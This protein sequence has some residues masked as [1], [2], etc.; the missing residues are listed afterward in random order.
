MEK[1]SELYPSVPLPKEVDKYFKPRSAFFDEIRETEAASTNV[2]SITASVETHAIPASSPS[3]VESGDVVGDTFKNSSSLPQ[4]H[5][6]HSNEFGI[7]SPLLGSSLFSLATNPVTSS[8]PATSFADPAMKPK[9]GCTEISRGPIPSRISFSGFG[10]LNLFTSSGGATF[11]DGD[12]LA[13]TE[14][15]LPVE[16]GVSGILLGPATLLLLFRCMVTSTKGP[17]GEFILFVICV[18]WIF[19]ALVKLGDLGTFGNNVL[20]SVFDDAWATLFPL[21]W[22]LALAF[23]RPSALK[24]LIL[25]IATGAIF[26]EFL[27]STLLSHLRSIYIGIIIITGKRFSCP[28]LWSYSFS[29]GLPSKFNGYFRRGEMRDVTIG[30]TNVYPR[31][32][33]FGFEGVRAK[34]GAVFWGLG[35]ACRKCSVITSLVIYGYLCVGLSSAGPRYSSNSSRNT[36][37]GKGDDAKEPTFIHFH[38]REWNLIPNLVYGL[39]GLITITKTNFGIINFAA[40]VLGLCFLHEVGSSGEIICL[41]PFSA[42]VLRRI[43]RSIYRLA[44]FFAWIII[45]DIILLVLQ[46]SAAGMEERLKGVGYVWVSGTIETVRFGFSIIEGSFKGFDASNNDKDIITEWT[47]EKDIQSLSEIDKY[48]VLFGFLEFEVRVRVTSFIATL[49]YGLVF[50]FL[51][52]ADEFM[53]A[54]KISE[55]QMTLSLG[56]HNA[57]S[58]AGTK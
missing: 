32:S 6:L 17:M 36:L 23:L 45:L 41:K 44:V 51:H 22:P 54:P 48:L 52:I 5:G 50:S 42:R 7:M 56:R 8:T 29:E 26:P 28:T 39:V 53:M 11:G 27:C 55:D 33:L 58:D 25:I 4:K 46:N 47:A 2:L 21:R 9:F 18:S 12:L 16:W 19:I 13:D 24:T 14:L 35:S 37:N 40:V 38:L 3:R 43:A 57:C 15:T 10:N 31:D 34:I 1:I 20:D 49:T 30:G